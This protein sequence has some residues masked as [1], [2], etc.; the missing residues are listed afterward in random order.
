MDEK[1]Q[2]SVS[3]T[4]FLRLGYGL[5][6]VRRREGEKE[7]TGLGRVEKIFLFILAFGVL[8]FCVFWFWIGDLWWN[9]NGPL[10]WFWDDH[11][12]WEWS[13]SLRISSPTPF[14][15]C[16]SSQLYIYIYCSF[17]KID[18]VSTLSIWVL[19]NISNFFIWHNY[20]SINLFI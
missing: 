9:L 16:S 10:S 4:L 19:F 3:G 17:L 7:R 6:C 15:I 5:E 13:D 12:F 8:G 20:D 18:M 11:S 14:S 2:E 1:E